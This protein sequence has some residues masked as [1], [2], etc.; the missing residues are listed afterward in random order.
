MHTTDHW[1]ALSPL[2]GKLLGTG[3]A[4][5]AAVAV[6]SLALSASLLLPGPVAAQAHQGA[7]GVQWLTF[8][9]G[10]WERR[11]SRGTVE[12][13]WSAPKGGMLQGMGRT[14]RGDS[15][16]EY[17]FVVIRETAGRIRYE[18][19]P[20]GQAPNTFSAKTVTDTLVEFEDLTHDFPQRVG[21]RKVGSDSLIAWVDGTTPRGARHVEFPYGRVRCDGR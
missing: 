16:V 11:T 14:F 19:H 9:Q 20:S 17:E 6:A 8:L 3:A 10:C 5:D 15:L 1:F 2:M 18:A 7:V 4:Q 21:Y 12:E 13:R